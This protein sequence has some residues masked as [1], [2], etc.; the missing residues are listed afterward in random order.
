MP[1]ITVQDRVEAVLASIHDLTKQDVMIGIPDSTAGR[2]SGPI[3]NAA[4]GYI[5]ET[6]D[7]ARNLPARPFLVPGVMKV[8]AK[9]AE[10]LGAGAAKAL[11]GDRQ[12]GASSLVKAGLLA[13][14][15]VKRTITEGAGFAP[16]SLATLKARAARGRKGAAAEI[17]SRAAGNAPDA[18]NA[19]PLI[20]TGQL[21]NAVT[22]VLRKR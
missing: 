20:D 15:S 1:T 3:S 2:K 5:Q 14:S 9:A 17:A 8:E 22:Y 12:A 13:S 21:R 18:S 6:G 16:L 4:I 11:D 10:M 19:R 7:P